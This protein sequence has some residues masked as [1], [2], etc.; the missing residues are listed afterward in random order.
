MRRSVSAGVFV[1]ALVALVLATSAETRPST[2]SSLQFS[3]KLGVI[4][5][6]TDCPAGTPA[7]D[8]CVGQAGAVAVKGLGTVHVETVHVVD[9]SDQACP[10][11]TVEG[12][13]I[14]SHGTLSLTGAAPKCVNVTFGYGDYPVDITGSGKFS[15]VS[16]TGTV[17][18]GGGS[19]VVTATVKAAAPLFDL[20]APALTGA[21]NRTVR[22]SSGHGVRVRFA[23]KAHDDV[24]TAVPVSC[25][26][27]SGSVFR[28]GRTH[29]TCSAGDSSANVATRTFTVTV[30]L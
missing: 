16:G 28:V 10:K 24:D 26:P 5:G 12:D 1:A 15:G 9:P 13:L 11:G 2:T 22:S 25:K 18:N 30:K 21:T 17:A 8:H 19:Y 14:T 7:A 6:G 20:E 4:L 29:V 27:R 3:L 23:V